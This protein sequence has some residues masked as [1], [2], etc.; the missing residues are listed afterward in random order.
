M[1]ND[2]NVFDVLGTLSVINGNEDDSLIIEV[3]DSNEDEGIDVFD[4]L[5]IMEIINDNNNEE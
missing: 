4:I 5:G 2:V 3:A 1:H